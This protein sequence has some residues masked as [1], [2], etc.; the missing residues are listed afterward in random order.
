MIR[1]LL[2]AIAFLLTAGCA[3][4]YV[5]K[6]QNGTRITTQNKPKL[7]HGYYVFKDVQGRPSRVP[8]GRVRQI[9]PSSLAEEEK[10]Q[11]NI[12]TP[13]K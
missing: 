5:L 11:F 8:A 2:L 4:S 9:E 10:S 1:C 7:E 3:S 13:K 12:S 6:M